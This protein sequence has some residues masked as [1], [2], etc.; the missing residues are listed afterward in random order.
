L[1]VSPIQARTL[2]E[3]EVINKIINWPT[4]AVGDKIEITVHNESPEKRDFNAILH[5]REGTFV[6][7]VM[8]ANAVKAVFDKLTEMA[9]RMK[10]PTPEAS[11]PAAPP[12][13]PEAASATGA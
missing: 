5:G 2:V 9:D 11:P 13:E 1:I 4:V 6:P 7:P 10:A 8:Y 3:S 12:A